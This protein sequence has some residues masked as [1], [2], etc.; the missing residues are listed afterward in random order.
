M[1]E[2]YILAV[3][4]V[5]A[6]LGALPDT[7]NTEDIRRYHLDDP[8]P[9]GIGVETINHCNRAGFG[10]T[11]L[12]GSMNRRFAWAAPMSERAALPRS[13]LAAPAISRR[14]LGG[15]SLRF[16][17]RPTALRAAEPAA[18]SPPLRSDGR[19]RGFPIR[20]CGALFGKHATG[21]AIGVRP[22]GHL[23]VIK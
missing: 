3:K 21:S 17:S 2:G 18:P 9:S 8:V 10:V 4:R 5:S 12:D 19:C 14:N 6:F 23:S 15:P 11:G 16:R 22:T 1:Q 13:S 20:R 7:A